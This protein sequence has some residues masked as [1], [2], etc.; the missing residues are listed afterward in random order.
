MSSRRPRPTARIATTTAHEGLVDE[1]STA[2][3]RDRSVAR[4]KPHRRETCTGQSQNNRVKLPP[5]RSRGCSRRWRYHERLRGGAGDDNLIGDE[6]NSPAG[7]RVGIPEA[8][9]GNDVIDGGVDSDAPSGT[10]PPAGLLPLLLA[11][12]ERDRLCGSAPVQLLIRPSPVDERQG[13]MADRLLLL[14]ILGIRSPRDRRS[15]I[16][17]RVRASAAARDRC[18]GRRS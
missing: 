4:L 18:T 8:G 7:N 3:A 13:S 17:L 11:Q 6:S 2:P 9:R 5:A 14:R 1:S 15:V 12:S 10:Q 16:R